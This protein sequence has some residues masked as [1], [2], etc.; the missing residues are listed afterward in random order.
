M[1]PILTIVT[2]YL[3]LRAIGMHLLQ[4]VNGHTYKLD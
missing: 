2:Q 1:N 4:K 3:Q